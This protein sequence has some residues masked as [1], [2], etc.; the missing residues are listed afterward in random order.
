MDIIRFTVGDT[1]VLKKKHPCAS[2][3]FRVVRIGSDVKIECVGCARSLTI[4]REVLERS[5]KKVVPAP[6]AG[7]KDGNN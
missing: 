6:G 7:V 1:L 5:I 3:A 2:D 4:A